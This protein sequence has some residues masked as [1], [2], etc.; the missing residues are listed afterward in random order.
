MRLARKTPG[1][2][3][4]DHDCEKTCPK[5]R[6]LTGRDVSSRRWQF[7]RLLL[8][9]E[10]KMVTRGLGPNGPMDAK[11]ASRL[12]PRTILEGVCSKL[13]EHESQGMRLSLVEAHRRPRKS[14]G[15]C[16]RSGDL[17][18]LKPQKLGKI[19]TISA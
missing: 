6:A 18:D 13:M 3:A 19:R 16:R 7:G 9:G 5:A 2:F 1:E 11:L 14:A 4:L 12:C 17:I 10:P 15:T 8:P